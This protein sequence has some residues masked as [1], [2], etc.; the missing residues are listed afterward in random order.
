M[1]SFYIVYKTFIFAA[2]IVFFVFKLNTGSV[3]TSDSLWQETKFTIV[4]TV[5]ESS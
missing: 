2:F 1:Y 5:L 4:L 3:D